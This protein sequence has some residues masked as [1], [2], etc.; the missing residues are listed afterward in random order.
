MPA[1][2]STD[3]FPANNICAPSTVYEIPALSDTVNLPHTTR[4]ITCG[5]SGAIKVLRE[6]GVTTVTIPATVMGVEP[7]QDIRAIRIFVTGTTVNPA[8]IFVK[9]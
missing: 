6:D 2:V 8:D 4:R 5:S 9:Y 7:M 3:V 1:D